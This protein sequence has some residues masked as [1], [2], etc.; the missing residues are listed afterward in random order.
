MNAIV[1]KFLLARDKFMPGLS[2]WHQ[3]RFTYSGYGTLTKNNEE[4]KK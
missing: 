4:N 3:P 1:N 2:L